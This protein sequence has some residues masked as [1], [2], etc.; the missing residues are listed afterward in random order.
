MKQ[1]LKA[2]F[3]KHSENVALVIDNK[4]YTYSELY[5]YTGRILSF[6][7]ANSSKKIAFFTSHSVI[8]YATI[9][10]SVF[11]S[12]TFIPINKKYSS[13]RVKDIVSQVDIDII[14]VDSSSMDFFKKISDLFSKDTI[15]L[16]PESDHTGSY[17]N[18]IVERKGF[19]KNYNTEIVYD[20]NTE[21]VS[22]I[23][24]TSGSTGKPKG[25]PISFLNLSSFLKMNLKLYN[26]V[27]SDKISQTFDLSFDL[28][29][30][31]PFMSWCSGAGLYVLSDTDLLAPVGFIN[32]K[33]ITIWFSVPYIINLAEK[34]NNE[35]SKKLRLSLFCG[36]PLLLK[37]ILI[38]KNIASNSEVENLYGP[39][40]LTIS[41][42]RYRIP[43]KEIL[44]HNGCVSIGNI[45]EGLDYIVIEDDKPSECGELCIYG[46]QKFDKYL[47][48]E[49]ATQNS[50]ITFNNKKYYKTGDIVSIDKSG[51]LLFRGR[52]DAQIKRRGYRI[53]LGDIEEN[54]RKMPLIENAL[55]TVSDNGDGINHITAFVK[56]TATISAADF[57]RSLEERIPHYIMPD[58]VI[59]I[60][61]YPINDNGKIDRKTLAELVG[62]P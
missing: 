15:F 55:C 31:G 11:G 12:C 25:V 24:F 5:R 45:Y 50:H 39:T 58:K 46:D 6:I 36:E 17:P 29:L 34:N 53:E 52:K 61:E 21:F 16:F 57:M 2:S 54:I 14:V 8:S 60:D 43:G 44:Q 22:Y 32:K 1:K 41:C 40:E 51:N 18:N 47:N 33:D 59:F 28:S 7:K 49:S 3:I 48:N 13:D 30:F 4:S 9:L 27:S 35:I 23:L 56:M 26:V 42:A 10:A 20:D 62:I 37:Q 38:W 19:V